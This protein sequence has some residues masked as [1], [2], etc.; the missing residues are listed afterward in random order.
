MGS[1]TPVPN[2]HRVYDLE[3]DGITITA[4]TPPKRLGANAREVA[5]WTRNS[6]KS[7]DDPFVID[8]DDEVQEIH[9]TSSIRLT[10][11]N[12][13]V[14]TTRALLSMIYLKCHRRI[15]LLVLRYSKPRIQILKFPT[16]LTQALQHLLVHP[17]TSQKPG[18]ISLLE[19]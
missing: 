12:M 6:G 2:S 9:R 5:N 15:Q 17:T 10:N 14:S 1:R 3:T 7:K 13:A 4:H 19:E 11:H 18:H 16:I 8:D